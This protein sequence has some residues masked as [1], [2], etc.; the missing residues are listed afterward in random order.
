MQQAVRSYLYILFQ[1]QRSICQLEDE[2][3]M[4]QESMQ[5]EIINLRLQLQTFVDQQKRQLIESQKSE[6]L[7]IERSAEV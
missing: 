5:K 7:L 6:K 3:R 1:K 4:S 2:M